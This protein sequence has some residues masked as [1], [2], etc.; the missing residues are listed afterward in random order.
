MLVVLEPCVSQ[1]IDFFL[2][3]GSG[4]IKEKV[5][6]VDMLLR[7]GGLFST[8]KRE[9]HLPLKGGEKRKKGEEVLGGQKLTE[10]EKK[11]KKVS[12]KSSLAE[13]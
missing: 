3:F 5:V 11:S 9:L 10:R 2:I 12:K 6:G 4:Q 8:E 1:K 7:R 13:G